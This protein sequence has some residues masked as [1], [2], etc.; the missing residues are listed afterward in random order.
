MNRKLQH[1]LKAL[2]ATAAVFT[3]L[4][5]AGGP[6]APA[7]P[8]PTTQL[9]GASAALL[10]TTSDASIDGAID[11]SDAPQ[12]SATRRRHMRHSR[13]LLA[14]PYISFAQGLRRNRS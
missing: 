6:A 4:L 7:M 11:A 2:S 3:V 9:S 13:E 12:P 10:D 8:A 1:T 14:L 5:L